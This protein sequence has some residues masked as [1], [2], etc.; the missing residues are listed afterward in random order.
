MEDLQEMYENRSDRSEFGSS[1]I[2]DIIMFE[3]L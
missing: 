3:A 2:S 1:A